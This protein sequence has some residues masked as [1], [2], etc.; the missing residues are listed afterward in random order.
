VLNQIRDRV[1]E[2][3][4]IDRPL[5]V[6]GLMMLGETITALILMAADPRTIAGAPAW[7]KPAKFG[8]SIAIYSLTLAWIFGFLPGWPRVRRSVSLTT[9][10]IL[11]LEVAIIVS[12]AWR[13]TT[14]HFNVSTPLDATLFALMGIGILVQTLASVAVAVALWRQRFANEEMGWAL[15]A[16][17]TL[18]IVGALTGGLMTRPTKAQLAE[19]R[20]THR[21]T[22]AGAHSVGAPDGGPGFPGT[23]WS[24]EHGDLRV[25]HFA[26]LHSVQLL[27]LF[28]LVVTRRS[29]GASGVRL[30]QFAAVSYALLFGIL[31]AQ[32]LRGES[33]VSP[34][35]T[36]LLTLG[37]W[38]AFTAVGFRMTS[39]RRY[40]SGQPATVVG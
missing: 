17:L 19:T 40:R 14:S 13:G 18:T 2:L 38:A 32:A 11:P 36:T 22:T 35:P 15:R 9:S 31:L 10:I 30:V 33:I 37:A 5:T 4:R 28:A 26:G 24:T 34:G 21:M 23:G 29:T 20:A 16:G 39:V 1:R 25:P 8:A 6:V 3:W 27:A 7:L 12:Q